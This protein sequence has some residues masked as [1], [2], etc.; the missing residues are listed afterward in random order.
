MSRGRVTWRRV[1]W[2]VEAL[3]L[4]VG[5]QA[6]LF[7]VSVV[8]GTSM[9]P[10]IH[11][12][13]LI[14]VD[15]AAILLGSQIERGDVVVLEAPGDPEVDY[16]KRVIGLPGETVRIAAGHVWVDGVEILAERGIDRGGTWHVPPDAFFVL[17]DNRPRSSDSRDF[18]VIDR[19]AIKGKVRCCCWPFRT[20]PG[21]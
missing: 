5:L 19:G 14:L 20:M 17:G 13:D 1:R 9:A 21:L 16:V 15:R 10:S 3:V 18:G 6:L 12:G 4:L 7:H 8:R 11:D 2:S